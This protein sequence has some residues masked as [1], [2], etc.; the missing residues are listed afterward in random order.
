MKRMNRNEAKGLLSI[1]KDRLNRVKGFY[2]HFA[3]F[4]GTLSATIPI[5]FV[6]EG[7][8]FMIPLILWGPLVGAH[9]HRVFGNMGKKSRQWEEEVL[10]ELMDG[11]ITELPDRFRRRAIASG[12]APETAQLEAARLR[13]RLETLEAIVTSRDWDALEQ[14]TGATE[15]RLLAEKVQQD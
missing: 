5:S 4:I 7:P 1:Y 6:A 13:K 10:A 8:V 3:G 14:D 12:A 15:G 2:Q 11:D 9:A